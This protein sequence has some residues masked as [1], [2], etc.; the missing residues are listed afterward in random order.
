[1][2][3]RNRTICFGTVA[4]TQWFT[5]LRLSEKRKSS[6]SGRTRPCRQNIRWVSLFRQYENIEELNRRALMALVDKILIYENHV[7]EIV[8][9]YRDEYEQALAFASEYNEE[10]RAAV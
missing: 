4:A 6:R 7:M 10:I 1:M 2:R 5:Q 9:K 8:F 3:L